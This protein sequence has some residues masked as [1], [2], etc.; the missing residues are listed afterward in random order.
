MNQFNPNNFYGGNY[1]NAYT[2][3][4]APAQVNWTNPLDPE[5][6]KILKEKAPEFNLLEI[7]REEALRASCT[8]RDPVNKELTLQQNADGSFR[9]VKCGAVFNMTELDEES[10]AKHVNSIV[11]ILQ[12]A[13]T[14]YLDMPPQSVVSYFQMIPFIEKLPEL[15]RIAQRTF[16]K[17][18]AGSGIQAGFASANPYFALQNAVSTPMYNVPGYGYQ[19]QAQAPGYTYQQP[20]YM[21]QPQQPIMN[22]YNP[23]PAYNQQYVQQPYQQGN[24]FQEGTPVAP[25]QNYQQAPVQ[26]QAPVDDKKRSGQPDEVTTNKSFSV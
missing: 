12:T 18:N 11:D 20:Q 22:G 21:Q 6:E 10:V 13:K 4:Q 9:C 14:M 7:P 3:G 2:Y 1:G 17:S 25:N 15:Y 26:Q 5:G 23:Q 24:V 19:G 8:H 16:E